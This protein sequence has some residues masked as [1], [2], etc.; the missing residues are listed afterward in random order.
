M[1]TPPEGEFQYLYTLV[2]DSSGTN[3]FSVPALAQ[4]ATFLLTA[5]KDWRGK[6]GVIIEVDHL[7]LTGK[8]NQLRVKV[9]SKIGTIYESCK[10]HLQVLSDKIK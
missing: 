10:V 4:S 2:F 5:K 1:V 7:D 6:H 8:S 3:R 9:C